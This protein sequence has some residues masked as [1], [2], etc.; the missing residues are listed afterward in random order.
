M[1]RTGTRTGPATGRKTACAVVFY[2]STVFAAF[3]ASLLGSCDPWIVDFLDVEASGETD[4]VVNTGDAADDICIWVH[5]T[6]AGQSLVIG[7]DKR[8]ALN[9]YNLQG[10]L[11]QSIGGIYPNN[12]DVRYG[13]DLD[14]DTVD[15][16]CASEDQSDRILVFRVDSSNPPDYL[17]DVSSGPLDAGMDAYGLCMYRSGSGEYYVFLVGRTGE[18]RQWRLDSTGVGTV[19]ITHVRTMD[20]G[21]IGEGCAA[22]DESA[23]LYVS[24]E[25][26]GIWRYG[27]DPG[28]GTAR[29]P[30]DSILEN[31]DLESDI[32]GL[33]IY[34][35]AGGGGYLLASV[36]GR[37]GYAV[38]D[39]TDG[40]YLGMFRIVDGASTDGT[41]DTDGIDVVNLS[42]GGGFSQGLFVAQDGSNGSPTDNQNFKLVPWERIAG[43][44]TPSLTID[45]AYG[46]RP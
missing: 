36:Q 28:A 44:F 10:V 11:L 34:R 12:V 16:V 4:P 25:N 21:S 14:G 40:R 38:Y 24:E 45:A 30:V 23:Y 32:E 31:P 13:F 42:L 46:V 3:A 29:I 41:A 18:I 2:L 35:S 7:T 5:P 43:A 9:V 17:V 37:S 1:I 6:D 39:R 8:G 27:A 20:L 22:D 33:A 15:L 26:V 19:G